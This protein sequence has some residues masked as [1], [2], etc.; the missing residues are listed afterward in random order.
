MINM[1][2]EN[3]IHAIENRKNHSVSEIE[4]NLEYLYIDYEA[5]RSHPYPDLAT[6]YELLARHEL[7]LRKANE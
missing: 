3:L 6:A 2:K 7:D 5:N 4:M 1:T